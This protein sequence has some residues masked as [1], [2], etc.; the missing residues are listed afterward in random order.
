[1]VA[2]ATSVNPM[3]GVC[4]RRDVAVRWCARLPAF[5][6]W[7]REAQPEIGRSDRRPLRAGLKARRYEDARAATMRT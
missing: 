3:A 5:G 6:A 1:M 4:A 7:R 2:A